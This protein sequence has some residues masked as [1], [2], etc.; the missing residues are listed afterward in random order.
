MQ[1][2]DLKGRYDLSSVTVITDFCTAACPFAFLC[3]HLHTCP[4]LVRVSKCLSEQ[5]IHRLELIPFFTF[6]D[7]LLADDE[8]NAAVIDCEHLDAGA[9]F[10]KYCFLFCFVCQC[11]NK[12]C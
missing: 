2:M 7:L 12:G 1:P 11:Y 8:R 5:C 4:V 9:A 3:A 10:A 6:K